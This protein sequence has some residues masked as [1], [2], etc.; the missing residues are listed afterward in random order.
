MVRRAAKLALLPAA[1][2]LGACSSSLVEFDNI[3]KPD[4]ATL[5]RPLSVTNYKDQVQEPVTAEELVDASGRCAGAFVPAEPAAVEP[6]AQAEAQPGAPPVV[7]ADT[8]QPAQA[9]GPSAVAL[10]ETG[11]PLNP[12]PVALNMS[13]C[14]VVKRAGLPERVEIGANERGDRSATLTY[15]QGPRPGIYRFTAG[16]LTSLERAPE[17]PPQPKPVKR[18]PK[19]KRTANR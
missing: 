18:A 19:P 4:M 9:A 15:I 13:E 14:D 6:A 16:R 5:F 1:L 11:V 8:P 2:A 10:Q 7:L 12:S 3:R 17:P